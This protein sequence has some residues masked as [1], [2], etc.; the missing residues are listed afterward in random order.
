MI[1]SRTY[2]AAVLSVV[3]V[4]GGAPAVSA[5]GSAR[6]R[7]ALTHGP[8]HFL[9]GMVG[10]IAEITV[11]N[12]GR[13][14]AR[15][16]VA[17]TNALPAG[18]TATAMAG[19]GWACAGATCL[20]SDPLPGRSSY[21][22]IRVVLDVAADVPASVTNTVQLN[23]VTSA[24]DVIPA[25][26]ACPYGWSPGAEVSFSGTESG[27][28][29]PERADGCTL[30]DLVWNAEPFADH[31][32]FVSTVRAVTNALVRE[33]L[34]TRREQRAVD[35][36]AARSPVGTRDDPKVDNSCTNRIALKFDDG[37]SSFRPALLKLLR[38]KQVHA[39]FFDNGIR[40]AANPAVTAFQAREGHLVLN[41]TYT[42]VHM[43]QL[44]ENAMRD[45]VLR[46]ERAL[47]AAGAPMPFRGI[48]P[49]FGDVNDTVLRVLLEL[50]YTYYL[51]I[52]DAEDWLPDKPA[53]AIADDILAQ[54]R[55]GAML[56]LHDGPIDT[57]A[58]AATVEATGLIID[59][60]RQLG[61][62]FGLVDEFG[63]VAADR[64]VPSRRPIPVV[65]NPV[66]YHLPLAF[67][68]VDDLPDPWFRIPSPLQISA[69]HTPV[70]F[71]R[72]QS[73]T[74]TLT[75]RNVSRDRTDG[76]PVTVI[77]A[78]PEG[79]VARAAT[80][81][82]WSCTATVSITCT[83]TDI[84]APQR[85]YPPITITVDVAPTA[86][87]TVTNAPTLTAHGDTWTDETTDTIPITGQP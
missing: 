86:P 19:A 68:T 72:N 16:L 39:T 85:S 28:R 52:G 13:S 33:N 40:V 63:Q 80:G 27:V 65:T 79:L 45:E 7:V 29:N 1:R 23:G 77:N 82:G 74:L 76:S 75:V 3:M 87:P 31:R 14:T 9:P 47:A 67:G 64:Y 30:L 81:P 73:G 66:P 48:R 24:T 11:S 41:H 42:H 35:A 20:R 10:A 22:P 62:C 54:L 56:G 57:T 59:R 78:L 50:G 83:R 53:T 71:S 32:T 26:D 18:L 25:R 43:D 44:S 37:D 2:L 51:N 61:Y 38:D 55:P 8:S 84:L 60:A 12:A 70:T 46:T 5:D 34:L 4:V 36:A 49:P 17:V 6:L 58:G 21:P 15:G 69:T